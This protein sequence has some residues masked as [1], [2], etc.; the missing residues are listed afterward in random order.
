MRPD[1]WT[2]RGWQLSRPPGAGL[3]GCRATVT[4]RG[5]LTGAPGGWEGVPGCQRAAPQARADPAGPVTSTISHPRPPGPRLATIACWP[6]PIR[7]QCLADGHSAPAGA[8]AATSRWQYRHTCAWWW[9]SSAQ[10][11]QRTSPADR[12]ALSISFCLGLATARMNT[13]RTPSS[14][15]TRN[16]PPGLPPFRAQIVIPA[17]PHNSAPITEITTTRSW[18]LL[19]VNIPVMLVNIP[20]TLLAHA[21]EGRAGWLHHR[22]CP[23]APGRLKTASR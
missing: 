19:L 3:P 11:G 1:R 5:G 13:P 2:R 17:Y 12:A 10:C 21:A 20:V 18:A 14:A 7:C 6:F 16:P 9:M 15:P 23:P 4:L 22:D 8:A